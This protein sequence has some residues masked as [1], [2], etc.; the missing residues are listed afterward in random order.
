MTNNPDE[1]LPVEQCDRKPLTLTCR[2]GAANERSLPYGLNPVDWCRECGMLFGDGDKP[3][4]YMPGFPLS[5]VAAQS[6]PP[7]VSEQAERQARCLDKYAEK[8]DAYHRDIADDF[9]AGAAALR[10]LSSPS[11][12]CDAETVEA[13]PDLITQIAR[14]LAADPVCGGRVASGTIEAIAG[15]CSRGCDLE[16]VEAIARELVDQTDEPW[17]DESDLGKRVHFWRDKAIKGAAAI[18]NIGKETR[19]G[20]G[21]PL[22]G[23]DRLGRGG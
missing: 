21:P 20:E 6:P 3:P 2:C 1:T 23:H 8:F 18:R 9:R 4:R 7:V 10:A 17:A 14:L 13:S 11:R 5:G 22:P 12:G 16:T 19:E 15:I